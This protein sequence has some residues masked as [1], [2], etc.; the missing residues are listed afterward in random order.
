MSS[1][2]K[3]PAR[4]TSRLSCE[5]RFSAILLYRLEDVSCL[6]LSD[7]LTSVARQTR[8]FVMTS[9]S[10]DVYLDRHSP[11]QVSV[12]NLAQ[13]GTNHREISQLREL[14][15]TQI[16]AKVEKGEPPIVVDE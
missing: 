10:F 5:K 14:V 2:E 6:A 8:S 1:I 11:S 4:P 3:L 15:L 13:H 12:A 9:F 7:S 16:H